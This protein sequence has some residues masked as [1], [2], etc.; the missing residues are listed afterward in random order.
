LTTDATVV[1]TALDE[2]LKNAEVLH[3]FNTIKYSLTQAH[4]L[5]LPGL[6]AALDGSMPFRVQTDASEAAVGVGLMHGQCSG[7]QPV[8][9]ALTA[10]CSAE[11]NDSVT[12]T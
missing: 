1:P 9:F 6:Q 3:A 2:W 8:A 5:I 12:D 11:F 4:V 10:L 7:W